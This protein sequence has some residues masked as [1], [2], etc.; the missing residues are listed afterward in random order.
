MDSSYG[1]LD[2]FSDARKTTGMSAKEFAAAKEIQEKYRDMQDAM[3]DLADDDE[4][5]ES[6]SALSRN[7]AT[8]FADYFGDGSKRAK[9][10]QDHLRLWVT[11]SA[12]NDTLE[13]WQGNTSLSTKEIDSWLDNKSKLVPQGGYKNPSQNQT[14]MAIRDFNGISA[15]NQDDLEKKRWE[16]IEMAASKGE[17]TD[18]DGEGDGG[19][20]A[21]LKPYM[22]QGYSV[23]YALDHATYWYK[24]GR[25]WVRRKYNRIYPKD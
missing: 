19:A 11:I 9:W 18:G 16:M 20:W 10:A 23:A 14:F 1:W 17:D 24:Q 4:N 5:K 8:E 3:R 15:S 25:R 12:S 7:M 6:L 21:K 13:K 22:E 2:D